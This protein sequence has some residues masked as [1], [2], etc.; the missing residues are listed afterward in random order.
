MLVPAASDLINKYPQLLPWLLSSSAIGLL[1][2]LKR[3]SRAV[4]TTVLGGLRGFPELHRAVCDCIS[5]CD[6]N[7]CRLRGQLAEHRHDRDL[8]GFAPKHGTGP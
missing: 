3:L 5:Q 1:V 6:A 4:R 7:W 8:G 2:S